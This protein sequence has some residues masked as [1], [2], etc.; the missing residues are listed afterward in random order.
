MLAEHIS[1]SKGIV[2]VKFN[3]INNKDIFL[4]F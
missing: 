3:Y 4:L 1:N 2:E